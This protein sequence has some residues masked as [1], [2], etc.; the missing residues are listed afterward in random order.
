MCSL[1][2]IVTSFTRGAGN[3]APMSDLSVYLS[4]LVLKKRRKAEKSERGMG[5]CAT[6]IENN[7]AERE[8]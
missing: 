6:G 5:G 7:G 4:F 8:Y 1:L 3:K 2:E